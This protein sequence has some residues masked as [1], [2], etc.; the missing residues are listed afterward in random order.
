VTGRGRAASPQR[1]NNRPL[2][3]F[4]RPA[5]R[6]LARARGS[7]DAG[8]LA[9]AAQAAVRA[10][11][12]GRS[13]QLQARR[14]ARHVLRHRLRRGSCAKGAHRWSCPGGSLLCAP[15]V[16]AT[17]SPTATS[18]ADNTPHSSGSAAVACSAAQ[19][20]SPNTAVARNR[21]VDRA[22]SSNQA[23][24]LASFRSNLSL[25]SALVQSVQYGAPAEPYPAA[26]SPAHSSS[27]RRSP[28]T[29][30]AA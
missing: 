22:D 2:P 29:T 12:G 20:S 5:T 4:R 1:C 21:F 30:A 10:R 24:P 16:S 19:Q 9:A 3:N 18:R 25:I 14:Q 23:S 26:Q 6:P 28:I 13:V 27:R 15:T 17:S 8:A 11:R 7:V